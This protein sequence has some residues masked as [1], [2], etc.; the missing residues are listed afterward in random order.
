MVEVPGDGGSEFGASS[1]LDQLTLALYDEMNER[2]REGH[3]SGVAHMYN[4]AS[5]VPLIGR[6]VQAAGVIEPLQRHF[7][8]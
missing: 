2:I 7:D 4:S 1:S 5:L 8:R 3:T 6:F